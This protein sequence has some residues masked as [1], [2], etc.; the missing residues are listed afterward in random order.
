MILERKPALLSRRREH[1][2]WA[3]PRVVD[4]VHAELRV[5]PAGTRELLMVLPVGGEVVK[6]AA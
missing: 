3:L 4:S 2:W 6:K 1:I 5:R